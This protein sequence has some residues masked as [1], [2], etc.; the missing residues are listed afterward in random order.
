MKEKITRWEKQLRKS[1]FP[2]ITWD[3]EEIKDYLLAC[4]KRDYAHYLQIALSDTTKRHNLVLIMNHDDLG[5]DNFGGTLNYN[6]KRKEF[7]FISYSDKRN[8]GMLF[9]I[10]S[11]ASFSCYDHYQ[12]FKKVFPFGAS[13]KRL[14]EYLLTN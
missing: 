4:F 7:T 8:Y 11:G 5:G 3:H 6:T 2:I 12:Q 1:G 14:T 10:N 13:V 9:S